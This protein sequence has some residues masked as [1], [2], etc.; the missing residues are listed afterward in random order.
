MSND[1]YTTDSRP[2]ATTSARSQRWRWLSTGLIVVGFLLLGAG[3]LV[4]YLNSAALAEPPPP[5]GQ[6]D[7]LPS[8]ELVESTSLPSLEENPL[9]VVPEVELRDIAVTYAAPTPTSAPTPTPTSTPAPTATLVA[10][11][12][13]SPEPVLEPEA[14]LRPDPTPTLTP[15][16]V[17]PA[18]HPPTRIVAPA[19]ELDTG[20]IPVGWK[21][22]FQDGKPVSVWEVAE[23]AA[24]WHKNSAL[25]GSGGNI[26]FSGHHNV[27]GEVFRYLVDL[28][29]GDTV[30]L[31]ADDHPYTYT[32][33]ARFVV[34]DKGV[35]EEE[36]REN[37]RWIGP[38][39]D[40]RVTLV[41]CWPYTNNTHRVIVVAKPTG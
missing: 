6:V 10:L 1:K 3:G 5:V 20:V 12:S 9:P 11:E 31:Y 25:P 24:G 14:D 39:P 37:A 8:A 36:R 35:S 16:L 29:P 30:T 4:A 18:M 19:I 32:V 27:K 2:Q 41:T 17:A 21:E 26:V 13:G 28:D 22:A 38:F 15:T 33:E 34:R 40:E 23:Y 7:L